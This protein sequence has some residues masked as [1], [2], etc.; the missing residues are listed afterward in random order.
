MLANSIAAPTPAELREARLGLL[1]E[2][3]D[4][5]GIERASA[6]TYDALRA[7]RSASGVSW[8]SRSQLSRAYGGWIRALEAATKLI[9]Q[10]G[11]GSP[12]DSRRSSARRYS[13][14][15]DL[16]VSVE[17]CRLVI[18]TWPS[19]STYTRWASLAVRT[20]RRHG[21]TDPAIPSARA[22]IKRFGTWTRAVELAAAAGQ[23]HDSD[24]CILIQ[25]AAP[26]GVS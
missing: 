1:L 3:V 18:G 13:S 21:R 22:I 15:A 11:P 2:L 26:H 24:A 7:A 12:G 20:A 9:H 17:Q 4:S 25:R 8:P 14:R 10:A 5:V 23:A 16:L 19:R 6:D